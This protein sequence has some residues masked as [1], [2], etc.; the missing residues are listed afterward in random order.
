MCECFFLIIIIIFRGVNKSEF[1]LSFSG[2]FIC[3][4][5]SYFMRLWE[6]FTAPFWMWKLWS[7]IDHFTVVCLDTKPLSGSEAQGDLVLIQNLLLLIRKSFSCHANKFLVSIMS[8][9]PQTSLWYR[10]LV[11]CF[12]TVKWSI[13]D[14]CVVPVSSS[15]WWIKIYQSQPTFSTDWSKLTFPVIH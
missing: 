2:L 1:A 12:R 7:S 3:Q 14:Y 8:R 5:K 10:G 9:S 11:T 4:I 15:F 6:L 13:S